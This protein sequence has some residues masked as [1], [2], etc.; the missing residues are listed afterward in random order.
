MA[1]DFGF[2]DIALSTNGLLIKD[3]RS[4]RDAGLNRINFSIDTLDPDEFFKIAKSRDI[5]R[6]IDTV[7]DAI[8]AG[9]ETKVN[10]VLLR[11]TN[12]GSTEQ[13]IDW[14]LARPMTLRFIEL[15][16]TALNMK[17]SEAERVLGTELEPLLRSR[18]LVP[19]VNPMRGPNLR[20]PASNWISAPG[21]IHKGKVGLINPMSK[22]FCDDCN[23]LRV[24]ARGALRLCLFGQGEAPLLLD[25]A[26]TVADS[27]RAVIDKKPE[28]HNLEKNDIGNVST[29]RTIGG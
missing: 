28:R 15:M 10:A 24:T 1:A 27:V 21:Q 22:N 19:E 6:V 12:F 18:G 14:A 8:D 29:F 9:I 25:S 17:F 23:R 5:K 4:W 3:I 13:M 16:P 26:A 2:E 7:D 11:S 20:G